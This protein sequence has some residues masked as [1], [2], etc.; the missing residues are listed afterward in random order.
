M[1]QAIFITVTF[2]I[3][4]RLLAGFSSPYLSDDYLRYLLDGEFII[5]GVNPY[6]AI[7]LDYPQHGGS[8]VPLPEVKTVYPPLAEGLFAI[9]TL[10]GG[11]LLSWRLFGLLPDLFGGW[12][13][14]K[15]LIDLKLP[16]QW[17]AL[18]LWNPILLKEG[19]NGAH[20]DL[21]TQFFVISF[22]YFALQSRIRSASIALTFA[23]LTK[24][25]PIVLLPLWLIQLPDTKSRIKASLTF[26]CILGISFSLFFPLHPF[27][28]I[29]VFLHHIQGYGV[30]FSTLLTVMSPDNSKLLITSL[31]GA[32]I[33]FRSVN[34][35]VY[36]LKPIYVTLDIFLILFITSSMGFPW[37]LLLAM[38]LVIISN[39]IFLMIFFGLSHLHYYENQLGQSNT[40]WPILISIFFLIG[41]QQLW[42][43]NN[44]EQHR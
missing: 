6:G 36:K 20:L 32:I 27:G 37:Y 28:N 41:I 21:W 43:K 26:F 44:E 1:K 19:V 3:I 16:K 39:N 30:L 24:L 12:L 10:L 2:A 23:T 31:G 22:I 25:I 13:M 8:E 17:I 40:F 15:I 14:Y 34:L 42:R 4:F 11:T 35:N 33:I 9:N 18:Y 38:P 29:T 7:P 5:N